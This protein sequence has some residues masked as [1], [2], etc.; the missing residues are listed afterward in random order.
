MPTPKII[1]DAIGVCRVGEIDG[2]ER[3]RA[4]HKWPNSLKIF[5]PQELK[6]EQ[7][8]AVHYRWEENLGKKDENPIE[9]IQQWMQVRASFWK[10]EEPQTNTLRTWLKR[11][12][13]SHKIDV[14]GLWSGMRAN[15]SV[16]AFLPS[17]KD[18]LRALDKEL[19]ITLHRGFVHGKLIARRVR[20]KGFICWRGAT[21]EGLRGIDV[22]PFIHPANQPRDIVLHILKWAWKYNPVRAWEALLELGC[23]QPRIVETMLSVEAHPAISLGQLSRVLGCRAGRVSAVV[24]GK[25]QT[26]TQKLTIGGEAIVVRCNPPVPR[27]ADPTFFL[28]RDRNVRDLFSRWNQGIRLDEEGR[29]SLTPEEVAMQLA[30]TIEHSVVWDAFCGCGGNTIAFARQKHIKKVIAV[31]IHPQRLEMAKH[32]AGLYG[33]GHKIDFRLG[34]V[35]EISPKIGFVFADPPWGKGEEYLSRVR[36]WAMKNFS[37]GMLKLPIAMRVPKDANLTLICTAEGYPSFMVQSWKS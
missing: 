16:L 34:N 30:Q 20:K 24:A 35:L 15:R 28:P 22:A 18:L 36:K 29:Y 17:K 37:E 6:T 19:T 4:V 26:R 2:L 21:Q 31:D 8:D 27:C 14:K 12:S 5:A 10:S 32:N 25:A 1:V 23:I 33:V 3:E 9:K 13:P 11:I 7:Q